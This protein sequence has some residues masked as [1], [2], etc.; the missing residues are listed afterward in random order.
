MSLLIDTNILIYSLKNDMKVQNG[1]LRNEAVPKA[2]SIITYGELLY[3]AKKSKNVEKN[4][5]ILYRIRELFPIIPIDIPVMET[6]G[7]LKARYARKGTVIDD[8]DLLIAATALTYN[9]IL[10]TNNEKHFERIE[11]LRMENW[12]R[13]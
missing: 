11:G 2:I 7:N 9:H 12:S 3:G 4:T 10:V 13:S 1:F 6:F 8:F 5:A